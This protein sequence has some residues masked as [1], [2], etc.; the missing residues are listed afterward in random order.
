MLSPN[1]KKNNVHCG[2]NFRALFLGSILIK[3]CIKKTKR[4]ADAKVDLEHT[5]TA[6]GYI[7]YVLNKIT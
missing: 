7:I 3:N 2:Q 4:P 5:I 6:Y 1:S